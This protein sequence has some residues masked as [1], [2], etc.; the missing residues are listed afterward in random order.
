MTDSR[1]LLASA[2]YDTMLRTLLDGGDA[3]LVEALNRLGEG[4]GQ[5]KFRHA[6]AVIGGI[7]LGRRAIDD[8][9]ALRRIAEYPPARRHEAVGVVAGKLA[10]ASGENVH[11]IERRL[12]RKLAKNE[13]DKIVIS[14]V[15]TP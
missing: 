12:R 15:S 8:R 4:T 3:A 9:A 13:T 14:V 10:K 11:S 7:R 5:N 1:R 6:G 2:L